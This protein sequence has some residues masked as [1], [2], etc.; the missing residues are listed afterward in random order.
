MDY[1]LVVAL[2]G[3]ISCKRKYK[4]SRNIFLR[5]PDSWG[6]FGHFWAVQFIIW[7][8]SVFNWL[9]R[10]SMVVM[11]VMVMVIMLTTA[12]VIMTTILYCLSSVHPTLGVHH[13]ICCVGPKNV[14]KMVLDGGGQPGTKCRRRRLLWSAGSRAKERFSTL[15]DAHFVSLLL[16]P[17]S[18]AVVF[19]FNFLN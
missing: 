1:T 3:A 8:S 11:V 16:L 10:S 14:H 19:N 17:K 9:R 2:P 18:Q 5:Y 15:P 12:M 13:A 7:S 4:H 6:F